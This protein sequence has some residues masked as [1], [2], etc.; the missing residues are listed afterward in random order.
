M[1]KVMFVSVHPDD[2]TLG[3][4]GTILKHSAAG[5]QIYWLNLTGPSL[6]H[7]YGFTQELIDKRT[8]QVSSVTESYKF[9]RFFNLAFP[10]QMLDTV[11]TRILVGAIDEVISIVK[12][13]IIYLPNRSDVH[14][15]HRVA[16]TAAYSCTKNFRKPYIK[17]ILMYETLSETEF[18][19]ALV[20]DSFVPNCF[21]DIT[22]NFE[23]KMEIM[24][25][26]DTE[27][28][29]DP[30]PRSNHAIKALASFR[31]ARIGALY[32]EAF[33]ILYRVE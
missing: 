1:E 14:S 24:H 4:G 17:E 33:M 5:N 13:T 2:E 19:P 21:V 32:A 6:T 31:G 9:D 16:F 7:P 23:K 25:I 27:V 29:P 3:C 8:S 30:Y 20:N 15:D 28:Q 18:A 10:T 22:D 11:E 12:P 26:Y